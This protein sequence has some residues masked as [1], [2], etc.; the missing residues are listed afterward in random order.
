MW[1]ITSSKY[2]ESSSSE[3]SENLLT[4][5]AISNTNLFNGTDILLNL[6]ISL[7]SNA[8]L[9]ATGFDSSKTLSSISSKFAIIFLDVCKRSSTKASI[10]SWSK[11]PDDSPNS[12]LFISWSKSDLHV[13][14]N[15]TNGFRSPWC[16]VTRKSFPINIDNWLF[17]DIPIFCAR[18]GKCKITKKW[19]S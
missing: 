3:P 12:L 14:T 11:S 8:I 19:S 4:F 13:F 6:L 9:L 17:F 18:G 2:S 7:L 5:F 15:S 16:T 1:S 10:I